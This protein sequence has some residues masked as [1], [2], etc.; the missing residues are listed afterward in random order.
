[1]FVKCHQIKN[2]TTFHTKLLSLF[3]QLTW[4]IRFIFS[5][6][7]ESDNFLFYIL[8]KYANLIEFSNKIKELGK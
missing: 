3:L 1:M 7:T 8:Q 2:L 4:N 6:P 5:T